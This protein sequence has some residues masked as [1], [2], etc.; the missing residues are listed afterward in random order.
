MMTSESADHGKF[1]K[2]KVNTGS[3]FDLT[4]ANFASQ[5]LYD[6]LVW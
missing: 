4:Q 1:G 5:S 6:K 3:C 2:K